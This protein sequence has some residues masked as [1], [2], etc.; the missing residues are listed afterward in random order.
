[1]PSP[2]TAVRLRGVPGALVDPDEEPDELEPLDE[3]PPLP[4][5]PEPKLADTERSADSVTVQVV[6]VPEQAPPQPVNDLPDAGVAVSVTS[7]P[8]MY[9]EEHDEPQ[10]MPLG[11]DVTVPSAPPDTETDRVFV[12]MA[13]PGHGGRSVPPVVIAAVPCRGCPATVLNDPAM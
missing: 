13:S 5:P 1:L 7:V 2:G 3:P 11:L 6:A 9:A 4:P 10:A 8:V 12:E